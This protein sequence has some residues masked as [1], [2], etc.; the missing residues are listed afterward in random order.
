MS[1]FILIKIKKQCFVETVFLWDIPF[2][3]MAL[4]FN[5]L[6]EFGLESSTSRILLYNLIMIIKIDQLAKGFWE[7]FLIFLF[8]KFISFS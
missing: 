4:N 8:I 1:S 6:Q 2:W 3:L 7:I 5:A